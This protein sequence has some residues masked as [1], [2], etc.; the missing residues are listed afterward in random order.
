MSSGDRAPRP[1]GATTLDDLT[2]ALAEL[3]AW[4]GG[5]SY[6][7]LATRVGG[8]RSERG[9]R[10]G[11]PGKVTVYDCFRPGRRRLDGELYLDLVTVLGVPA[12]DL[13]HWR[14]AFRDVHGAGA[15]P[16]RPP[17]VRPRRELVGRDEVL[18][19]VVAHPPG[20]V[21]SVVG[22]AGIGKT[23]VALHV[24]RVWQDRLGPACRT[25]GLDA[26]GYDPER[27]PLDPSAVLGGLLVGL[28]VVPQRYDALDLAGRRELLWRELSAT[29]AVVLLDNVR[30]ATPVAALLPIPPRARVLVTGRRAL[31]GLPR[32][33]EHREVVLTELSESAALDL[34]ARTGGRDVRVEDR[35]AAERIVRACGRMALD[36]TVAGALVAA[37][38]EWTLDDHAARLEALPRDERLRPALRMGHDLL[39]VDVAATLRALALH[40]GPE[41]T[42][43]VVAALAGVAEDVAADHLEQ[44]VAE[45]LLRQDGRGR[46]LLHDVVRAFATHLGLI[47]DPRSAQQA[48]RERLL[49]TVVE[50]TR[51]HAPA[52]DPDVGWLTDEQS[53][54][55]AVADAAPG[56]GRPR[57]T[58]DVALLL[59]DHLEVTGQWATCDALCTHALDAGV[60]DRGVR[61]LRARS[62]EM[63]GRLDE[64]LAE[65]ER[66][67]DVEDPADTEAARVVNGI[68]NIHKHR[69]RYRD[70]VHAYARSVRLAAARGHDQAR[71]RALGN[72]AD[73]L[74]LL[75]HPRIGAEVYDACEE[76][77]ARAGDDLAL[78]IVRS[79]RPLLAEALGD[80]VGAVRLGIEAVTELETGGFATL[81]AI[82]RGWL[83][84]HREQ[85]GDLEACA[86]DLAHA[87][88]AL[89]RHELGEALALLDVTRGRLLAGQGDPAAG[90]RVLEGALARSREHGWGSPEVEAMLALGDL[91]AAGEDPATAVRWY[92]EAEA[93]AERQSRRPE[94]DRA[95]SARTTLVP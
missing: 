31:T 69:G 89:A 44:L 82:S 4:A 43:W 29:P 87:E 28:G 79:N 42:E 30:D 84:R 50:R 83:A 66:A 9:L 77:A 59:A 17:L 41:L 34:L 67:H 6:A 46:Y 18:R 57:A 16:E 3:R 76:Y 91:A 86:T 11:R 21:T 95:R 14:A 22:L 32:A 65:L 10:T 45:Q 7:A 71:G 24:A 53:S 47:V 51:E 1:V 27:P 12:G 85:V 15:A 20:G 80:P 5:P 54:L 37:Q 8:L 48:A 62:L 92:D 52:G 23:E 38:P 39:P 49:D 74:R 36:L 72:L 78:A 64:A 93:L 56:W 19:T 73:T 25:V 40:P 35:A 13:A 26:R 2:R 63:R 75:G 90:V 33:T 58:A 88:T 94:R 55:L 60:D 68:G 61:R 81:A 70:A